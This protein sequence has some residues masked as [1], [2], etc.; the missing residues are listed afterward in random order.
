MLLVDAYDQTVRLYGREEALRG[1]TL[2]YPPDRAPPSPD[3]LAERKAL[4]ERLGLP[5]RLASGAEAAVA[6]LAGAFQVVGGD[7]DRF[8]EWWVRGGAPK[9]PRAAVYNQAPAAFAEHFG[10]QEADVV[11]GVATG[12]S[13]PPWCDAHQLLTKPRRPTIPTQPQPK[14]G[15]AYAGRRGVSRAKPLAVRHPP[16]GRRS[17]GAAPTQA[18][19]ARGR[20]QGHQAL[21]ARGGGRR[22]GR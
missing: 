18:R 2:P 16:V 1:A 14:T 19:Q 5:Q 4:E 21:Q 13:R 17:A 9:Q 12:K 8:L 10:L 6:A 7:V 3:E 22:Q 11:S 15:R 20:R